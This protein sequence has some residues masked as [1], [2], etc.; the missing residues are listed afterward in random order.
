MSAEFSDG[1]N[2]VKKLFNWIKNKYLNWK[3]DRLL[4]PSYYDFSIFSMFGDH[5]TTT[6]TNITQSD[7]QIKY[8]QALFLIK[9]KI[10]EEA[11]KEGS[12]NRALE[13]YGNKELIDNW[14]NDL[15]N[16]DLIDLSNEY[17][18]VVQFLRKVTSKK[19]KDIKSKKDKQQMI[20]KRIDDYYYLQEK[21]QIRALNKKLRK[22][23]KEKDEL[24]I[25]ELKESID[26]KLFKLRR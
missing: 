1:G 4:A 12:L 22:A 21:R 3:I 2:I 20:S 17:N 15:Y 18:P 25:K 7:T 8:Q 14:K 23:E 19:E 10:K 5:K 6:N 11:K 16:K 24:Q 26:G 9:K 13:K